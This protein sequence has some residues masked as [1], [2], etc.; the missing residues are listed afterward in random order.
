MVLKYQLS[1]EHNIGRV[2]A[3]GEVKDSDFDRVISSLLNDDQFSP[4]MDMLVDLRKVIS[5]SVTTTG[6]QEIA[7]LFQ[8]DKR[9]LP[10]ARIAAVTSDKFTYG[11]VKMFQGLTIGALPLQMVTLDYGEAL[12]YLK[13]KTPMEVIFD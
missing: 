4:G 3:E 5:L 6:I 7:L 10:E 8:E 2:V 13:L 1:R 12:R 9:V 11:I